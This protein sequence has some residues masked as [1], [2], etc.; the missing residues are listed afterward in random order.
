[1]IKA[2]AFLGV[3]L[4]VVLL[5]AVVWVSYMSR[6]LFKDKR[7]DLPPLPQLAPREAALTFA[8]TEDN[9]LLLVT[10]ARESEI[11]AIDLTA[12]Y[13]EAATDPIALYRQLGYDSLAALT[14]TEKTYALES[15]GLPMDLGIEHLAAGTNFA[16]HAEEV[17]LDDPPFLFPK[18]TAPTPW[19]APVLR[20]ARLDYE[21]ELAFVPL[22]TIASPGHLPGFALLLTNDFTDRWALIR[23]IRLRE[24]MGTTGF[25]ASKGKESFLPAGYFLV[26]PK[27]ASF[28]EDIEVRLYVND[29]LRQRFT[30]GDMILGYEEIVAQ[31]FRDQEQTYYKGKAPFPLIP[32]GGIPRG[33]LILTGTAGGV[34]FKPVNIWHPGLYLKPGDVV[35]TEASYL[36]RL[37]NV[38]VG[39]GE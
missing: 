18:N 24:P 22:E 28:Y 13:G 3:A 35:R 12:L 30:A 4:L 21:A 31:S 11:L 6:P 19:N 32:E 29:R 38:V 5:V 34:I 1:M 36:G 10:G 33:S 2:V 8:R 16:E 26:I 14:G 39:V 23:E 37:E 17:N 20:A 15:L 25:A 9:R 7:A 27:E